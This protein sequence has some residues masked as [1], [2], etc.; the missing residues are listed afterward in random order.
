MY[1]INR[2]HPELVTT[3]RATPQWCASGYKIEELKK[4]INALQNKFKDLDAADKDI[5]KVIN[6][7]SKNWDMMQNFSHQLS[8][9]VS[10]IEAKVERI[11]DSN[12]DFNDEC[13]DEQI[14]MVKQNL[15]TLDEKIDTLDA[16]LSEDIG[17]TSERVDKEIGNWEKSHDH[18]RKLEELIGENKKKIDEVESNLLEQKQMIHI[19]E[20]GFKCEECD[21]TFV[22]KQEKRTHIK[23]CHPKHFSCEVCDK[24]F[25]ESW[26]LETHLESHSKPKS[27]ICDV[28]GKKFF[29][30]WRLRQHVN[31]HENHKIQN[32]H[33]YNNAQECPFERV[34]C[35]FKHM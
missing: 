13:L 12:K 23:K 30:E 16:K 2:F 27:N 1:S 28:C 22:K 17:I 34:G 26:K 11:K 18:Q 8:E 20:S 3:V 14:E 5:K 35:K 9:R 25:S 10:A 4:A 7:H 33:Y 32:C 24:V 29:L 19:V 21:K 6:S 15:E 31:V